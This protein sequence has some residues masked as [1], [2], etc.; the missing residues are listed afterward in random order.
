MFVNNLNTYNLSSV[1][2]TNKINRLKSICTD[3]KTLETNGSISAAESKIA[4]AF[5]VY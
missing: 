5:P 3:A 2:D 4:E 1:A